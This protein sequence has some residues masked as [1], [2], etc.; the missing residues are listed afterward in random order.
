MATL[1]T[2]SVSPPAFSF[3]SLNVV[4]HLAGCNTWACTLKERNRKADSRIR[5]NRDTEGEK[6]IIRKAKLHNPPQTPFVCFA[7]AFA[8][9]PFALVFAAALPFTFLP[10]AFDLTVCPFFFSF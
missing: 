7:Y 8:F 10:L 3:V 4:R 6:G 5:K 2:S 9:A 1:K